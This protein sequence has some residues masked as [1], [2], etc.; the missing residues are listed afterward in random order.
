MMNNIDIGGGSSSSSV[1]E[2]DWENNINDLDVD[3][4][5]WI[6]ELLDDSLDGS[7]MNSGLDAATITPNSPCQPFMSTINGGTN[8]GGSSSNVPQS[9]SAQEMMTMSSLTPCS[10]ATTMQTEGIISSAVKYMSTISAQSS[11]SQTKTDVLE[12]EQLLQQVSKGKE[13]QQPTTHL[14]ANQTNMTFGD[15][16]NQLQYQMPSNPLHHCTGPMANTQTGNLQN[17]QAL[18]VQMQQILNQNQLQLQQATRSS[19]N[20]IS[21]RRQQLNI[22]LSAP[23]GFAAP[24]TFPSSKEFREY[25][26][27][28]IRIMKE[29][30]YNELVKMNY[31]AMELRSLATNRDVAENYEKVQTYLEKMM[32]FLNISRVDL[33]P[34][35]NNRVYNYMN[36]IVNYVSYHMNRHG[37]SSQ[38]AHQPARGPQVQPFR[39]MMLQNNSSPNPSR[40]FTN[41]EANML[42]FNQNF[43]S[44]RPQPQ[45]TQSRMPSSLN[46]LSFQ[47]GIDQRVVNP[48]S[49]MPSSPISLFSSTSGTN[50]FSS[51][52]LNHQQPP[53]ANQNFNFEKMTAPMHKTNGLTGSKVR[54]GMSPLCSTVVNQCA[55]P[56]FS[57]QS[58][59]NPTT[60]QTSFSS[61]KFD[62]NKVL[63][64]DSIAHS[65]FL[66]SSNSST[67][68]KQCS[69][70]IHSSSTAD[71]QKAKTPMD[72]P[73]EEPKNSKD[74]VFHLTEVVKSISSN[75]LLST[76]SDISSIEKEMD[77][78]P[79]CVPFNVE[80]GMDIQDEKNI[81]FEYDHERP[82]KMRR[83]FSVASVDS[84][85][86]VSQESDINSEETSSN[87]RMKIE[88]KWEMLE[89]IKELNN[90]LVETT[91]NVVIDTTEDDISILESHEGTIVKCSF[92][93][94]CFPDLRGQQ[95]GVSS[96]KVKFSSSRNPLLNAV[97]MPKMPEFVILLL[98]P[99]NYPA[100]SP[101][102]IKSTCNVLNSEPW[103]KLYEEMLTK[104]DLSLQG[105]PGI[106]SLGDMARNWDA[107]A[108]AV[109]AEF[110]QKR[111][112][113][114]LSSR[115]G[116]WE[117]CMSSSST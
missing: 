117:N 93:N 94:V 70:G 77:I 105:I 25:V 80:K 96:E 85:P 62:V 54:H 104:F 18:R 8:L 55:S 46:G 51:R 22:N 17:S 75:A 90:K 40:G 5:S 61:S 6:E 69:S 20:L 86:L 84:D 59:V 114:S 27:R 89:E 42:T 91:I 67:L 29:R 11:D 12:Y 99:A 102:V 60:Q 21:G 72:P 16:K 112:V 47:V 48:Q 34:K 115:Y 38:P 78:I 43:P 107:S 2:V 95:G 15:Q 110:M 45:S 41:L 50:N 106:P 109:M 63:S 24:S 10:S 14:L 44:R 13:V 36:T 52:P 103:G 81:K 1:A 64:P 57:L 98:V 79:H 4:D 87:K 37:S 82:E 73:S 71:S 31:N 19:S 111:G 116:N 58:T 39:A 53:V 65:P 9:G 3:L 33:I 32:T 76:L 26:L 28:Q 92:R 83:E 108:R 35:N 74:Q 101:R 97:L 7:L 56:Q 68:S 23:V 88:I 66:L 49:R 113:K 100:S 30:Y